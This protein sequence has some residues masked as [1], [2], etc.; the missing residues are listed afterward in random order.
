MT[1]PTPSRPA[2]LRLNA[3]LVLAVGKRAG[4]ENYFDYA[5]LL[6]VSLSTF[7][8]QISGRDAPSPTVIAGLHIRLGIDLRRLLV[9]SDPCEV[10]QAVAS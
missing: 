1:N 6:C 4:L 2:E 9:A 7:K 3:E 8:R 5:N 10:A